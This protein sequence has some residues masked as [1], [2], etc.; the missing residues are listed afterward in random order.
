MSDIVITEPMIARGTAFAMATGVDVTREFMHKLLVHAMTPVRRGAKPSS[1]DPALVH[2]IFRRLAKGEYLELICEE[3][4]MPEADTL[5][6]WITVNGL[7]R[8]F[9]QARAQGI[10]AKF[11]ELERLADSATEDTAQAVRLQVDTRKWMLS[12]L[13]PEKY[14]DKLAIEH[15][16]TISFSTM[17]DTEVNSRAIRL[18][19][20]RLEPV[21]ERLVGTGQP[22]TMDDIV[23]AFTVTPLPG[24]IAIEHQTEAAGV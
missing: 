23:E 12:K 18:L 8:T 22:V 6:K 5:M 1:F 14:G 15:S 10:D 7:S 3:P 11:A 24:Q 9:A 21:F 20:A 19:R 4:D 13:K 2:A 17:P 16:G